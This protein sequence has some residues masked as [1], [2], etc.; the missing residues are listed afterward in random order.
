MNFFKFTQSYYG[1]THL[2]RGEMIEN[3][4]AST[5]IE[6]YRDA[7]E[8][9]FEAPISSGILEFLPIGTYVSHTETL[10]VMVVESQ[11]VSESNSQNAKISGRSLETLLEQRI[12][13][14]ELVRTYPP[15][16]ELSEYIMDVGYSHA[17]ATHLIRVHIN[18]LYTID[19]DN[20]LPG[21]DVSYDLSDLSIPTSYS[22]LGPSAWGQ[23][24][25]PAVLTTMT[26]EPR[27]IKR[28]TVHKAVLEIL[29]I[30]DLG[31]RVIR[32]G[33]WSLHN[34]YD[35][36][37]PP[38]SFPGPWTYYTYGPI[39]GFVVHNGCNRSY[40]IVFSYE[41]G[42]IAS[43]DYL[44]TNKNNKTHAI[45]SGKWVEVVVTNDASKVK[46]SRRIEHV[47]ASFLDSNFNVAPTGSDLTDIVSYMETIG[48]TTLA[49]KRDVVLMDV[50]IGATSKHVYRRDY[51]IGDLVR[52][53]GNYD[54][55]SLARV[56][57]HVEIE[58]ENGET[59]YP[60]LSLIE[61]TLV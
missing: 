9:T 1:A 52:V 7:G 42:D 46:D 47:D 53:E 29:S 28:T 57:E 5:W 61:E 34:T 20:A 13:G 37:K 50:E 58:D 18:D 21:F 6:R 15:T 22:G 40:D 38:P 4:S 26:T 16:T 30:D 31:L 60:T 49:S 17:Q 8:F 3:L 44:W 32:P 27:V 33:K 19:D 55:R 25:L 54:A 24:N 11:T 12:V 10:D 45:V 56:V 35:R 51:N 48:K 41:A 43:A 59:S 36:L 23:A 2:E 39:T 14:S